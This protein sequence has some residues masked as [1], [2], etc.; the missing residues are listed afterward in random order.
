MPMKVFF[1]KNDSLYKIFKTLEKLPTNKSVN[2]YI[3]PEHSFFDNE[4][5]WKQL[6][7][8][9]QERN[10]DAYFITKND[11]SKYFFQSLWLLVIHQEKSKIL[12]IINIIYLFFFNFKRF[13]LLAYNRKNYIFYVVFGFELAFVLAIFYVLYSLILP[14]WNIYIKSSQQSESIIY[15]F[16]YYPSTDTTYTK[17]SRFLSIPIFSW[18]IQHKYELS[19]S[20][21][22]IKYLQNP[23]RW[24]AQIINKT[25]KKYSFVPNTRLVTDD[26]RLFQ[27]IVWNE[28][29]AWSENQPSQTTVKIRAMEKD[30]NWIFMWSRWNIQAWTKLYI[31]NLNQSIYLNKVYAEVSQDITW[32]FISSQWT[33]TEKDIN[34]LS[35]KLS[36]YINQ[37]KKEIVSQ[38]FKINNGILIWFND[39]ISN[40]TQQLYIKNKTWEQSP[41]IQWYIVSNLNFYYIQWDDLIKWFSE[42]ISQRPSEKSKLVTI[43]KNSLVFFDSTKKE[44]NVVIIPTKIDIIQWYD[45]TKDINWILEDIK[46]NIVSI[47]KQQAQKI[48]LSYPEI[49]WVTIKIRPPRYTTLPKLKSRINFIFE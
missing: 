2:I 21:T 30:D 18:S 1:Q 48:I 47:D 39:T 8:L 34:I 45:F 15:N 28:I 4:R 32:W 38:N 13:H 6:K 19:I 36:D 37:N 29:P 46:N 41:I 16:R 11:R 12:R 9:I 35:S 26:W 49:A 42:Y 33:I 10:I 23:S 44:G 5:R 14:S 20:T 17:D 25:E 7:E 43:D 24:E 27:T 3:D 40:N 31:K 22:N